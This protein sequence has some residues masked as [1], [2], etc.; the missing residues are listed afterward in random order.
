MLCSIPNGVQSMSQDIPGLVQ[1]S[2][3]LGIAKLGDRFSLTT[4]TRSSVNA[5]KV[6]LLDQ[7][8]KLADMYGAS[9]ATQGDYPA[10]EYKKDSKLRDTMV[11]IYT[12]MFGKEPEVVAIHAG[13]ECGLLSEK[14]PGLDCVSIGPEMHDI[15]TS[16]EKLG[17]A[18]TERTWKFI[19]EV[20]KNL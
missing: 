8:K 13:L 10:W 11:K 14:L 7:L 19:L 18:S 17:I 6:E 9:Y 20:L 16:R 1:T 3:N 5:E 2:L 15:H 4:A 12:E